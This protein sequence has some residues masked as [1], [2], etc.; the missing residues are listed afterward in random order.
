MTSVNGQR[1]DLSGPGIEGGVV[2]RKVFHSFYYQRDSRRV[3][4]VKQ[5]GVLEG[6]PLLSSNQWEEI[7][8]G[9]E[10]AIKTWIAEQ[11]SGKSCVVVLIGSRTAGR[12]WVKH[13][14]EKGWNDK[15][16]LVGVY[17][18]NLKD[19]ITGK[20]TKGRN[21]FDG[22]TVGSDK[23]KLS[24]VVK[25]YDPPSATAYNHIKSNLEAWVEEAI[26]IRNNF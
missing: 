6:Q 16:G 23:K 20:D 10:S 21:P 19:P 12:K 18:H 7:K 8:R 2:A 4:Q 17:I 1:L 14:I 26:K 15:K 11:M 25:A 22:F 24:A 3:Q 9:G 5:M 13:E